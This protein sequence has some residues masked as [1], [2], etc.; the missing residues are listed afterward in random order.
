MKHIGQN[1]EGVLVSTEKPVNLEGKLPR[2]GEVWAHCNIVEGVNIDVQVGYGNVPTYTKHYI[3]KRH[4]L[5]MVE[6]I[7]EIESTTFQK[8]YSNDPF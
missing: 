3:P 5:A 8:Q 4:L 1:F 2:D 6:M 7:K